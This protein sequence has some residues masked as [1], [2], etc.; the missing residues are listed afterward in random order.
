MERLLQKEMNIS[1]PST[2]QIRLSFR[3]DFECEAQKIAA[4]LASF[5]SGSSNGL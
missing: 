4:A 1:V 3:I 2:M 5:E